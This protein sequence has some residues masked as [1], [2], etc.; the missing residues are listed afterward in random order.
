[1]GHAPAL[2]Q[3]TVLLAVTT[4]TQR[5][6]IFLLPGVKRADENKIVSIDLTHAE[7]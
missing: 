4:L 7:A 1:M 2:E 5:L 6:G 3:Q